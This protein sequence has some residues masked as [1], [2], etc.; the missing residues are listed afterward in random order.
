MQ[1]FTPI[2]I[3]LLC[4]GAVSAGVFVLGQYFATQ[5]QVQRRL[6]VP[7]TANA[8]RAPATTSFQSFIA[9]HFDE[10]RFGFDNTLRGKMRRELV[11]AGYFRRDAINIYIFARLAAAVVM[12]V[13]GYLAAEAFLSTW[14]AKL[15]VVVLVLVLAII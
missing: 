11:R 9:R 5:S 7:V 13:V 2:L 15:F 6:A 14:F 8:A 4:F 12:P 1:E 10:K 3:A